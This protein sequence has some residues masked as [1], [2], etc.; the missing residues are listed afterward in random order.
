MEQ[1]QRNNQRDFID[2]CKESKIIL[3]KDRTDLD[4][5]KRKQ[6]ERMKYLNQ[7]SLTNKQVK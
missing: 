6:A 2:N 5:D 1:K 4:S 7:Y 3:Q